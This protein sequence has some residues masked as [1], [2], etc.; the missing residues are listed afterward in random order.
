MVPLDAKWREKN[1]KI[2]L[3]QNP[4]RATLLKFIFSKNSRGKKD[5][6][7]QINASKYITLGL[8]FIGGKMWGFYWILVLLNV[9]YDF[10][11]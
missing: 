5:V 11:L 8:V 9:F 10:Y 6:F 2:I 4:M 3:V 7:L 1:K